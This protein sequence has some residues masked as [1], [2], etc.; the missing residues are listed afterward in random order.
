[1]D[2]AKS[3]RWHAGS[4]AVA[5]SQDA[6]Q[7]IFPIRLES[8]DFGQAFVQDTQL[9]GHTMLTLRRYPGLVK[10][11][12]CGRDSAGKRHSVGAGE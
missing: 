10:L 9:I 7:A 5:S 8:D 3:W 4:Q 11:V 2:A 1:M 12:N 6:I